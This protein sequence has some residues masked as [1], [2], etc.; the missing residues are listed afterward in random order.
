MIKQIEYCDRCGKEIKRPIFPFIKV[1]AT[2][3]IRKIFGHALYDYS[4][5]T[6]TLCLKCSEEFEM[7]MRGETNG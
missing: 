3:N 2:I 7:F 6:L 4:D 1:S 5:S